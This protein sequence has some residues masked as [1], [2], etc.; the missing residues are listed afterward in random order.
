GLESRRVLFRSLP[1]GL[2]PSGS[3]AADLRAPAL[4]NRGW[5]PATSQSPR[6]ACLEV[7]A[8]F[9]SQLTPQATGFPATRTSDPRLPPVAVPGRSFHYAGAVLHQDPLPAAVVR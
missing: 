9:D 3:G 1:A 8:R 6:L 7:S 2:R 4:R 5:P